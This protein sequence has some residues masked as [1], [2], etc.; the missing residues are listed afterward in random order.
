[1]E[2]HWYRFDTIQGDH[3]VQDYLSGKSA[4]GVPHPK[5]CLHF[6][7]T[8]TVRRNSQDLTIEVSQIQMWYDDSRTF[9]NFT[10]ATWQQA[11]TKMITEIG[12]DWLATRHPWTDIHPVVHGAL[13]A[14]FW[15]QVTVERLTREINA[16]RRRN[17]AVCKFLCENKYLSGVGNYLKSEILYRAKIHPARL[18][19]SLNQEDIERLFGATLNTISY[20]YQCGG[21]THGTFLDPDME[22]GTFPV[23]VYKRQGQTDENGH[24]I[25]YSKEFD[26]RGTF[27]VSAIQS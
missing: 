3:E 4:A 9:G 14:I 19:G 11:F 10:I 18:L 6:G 26:G 25:E 17:M 22:K 5:F 8:G 1:M 27:Y 16:P 12:A 2:G 20:A 21:L 7:R 15:D 23:K 13:P 24:V